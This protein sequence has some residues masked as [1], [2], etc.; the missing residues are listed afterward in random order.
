MY[1]KEEEKFHWTGR[2]S[3]LFKSAQIEPISNK[4]S[5]LKNGKVYSMSKYGIVAKAERSAQN[6]KNDVVKRSAHGK[7]GGSDAVDGARQ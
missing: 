7:R 2:K 4:A 6:C 3:R 5:V 1:L